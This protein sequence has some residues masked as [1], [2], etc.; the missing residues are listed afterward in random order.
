MPRMEAAMKRASVFAFL[1]ASFGA[2][3]EHSPSR[4]ALDEPVVQG[5]AVVRGTAVSVTDI[6]LTDTTG[7]LTLV[8]CCGLEDLSTCTATNTYEIG[9]ALDRDV[10]ELARGDDIGVTFSNTRVAGT[11]TDIDPIVIV[12]GDNGN[13]ADSLP[14]LGVTFEGTTGIFDDAL[15]GGR[16]YTTNGDP[17]TDHD[18]SVR[19]VSVFDLDTMPHEGYWHIDV[20]HRWGLQY[21]FT[22]VYRE[23]TEP[24]GGGGDGDDVVLCACATTP[25]GWPASVAAIVVLGAFVRR[26]RVRQA[27]GDGDAEPAADTLR[28]VVDDEMVVSRTPPAVA[29]RV[30]GRD[31]AA[32]RRL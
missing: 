8:A 7:T 25:R 13:P 22:W 1:L 27:T 20:S 24:I 23:A 12:S 11:C 32:H 15:V 28:L 4:W 21:E 10:T 5:D 6:V 2:R 31:R 19:T 30:D 14:G 3:A 17:H 26:R 16:Y 18:G 9:W 29:A